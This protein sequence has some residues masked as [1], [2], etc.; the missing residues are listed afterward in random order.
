MY[1]IYIYYMN[2]KET[3]QPIITR[4]LACCFRSVYYSYKWGPMLWTDRMD[5]GRWA[6]PTRL[7]QP[8]NNWADATT[9]TWPHRS[10]GVFFARSTWTAQSRSGVASEARWC[11][12]QKW[13][14]SGP[15][16]GEWS[17]SFLKTSS[18][19]LARCESE[20]WKGSD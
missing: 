20:Y 19:L 2:K 4:S 6:G 3:S 16:S 5:A 7:P 8:T 14:S 9:R 11:L 18:S 17:P 10:T 12:R 1:I 13:E 15:V